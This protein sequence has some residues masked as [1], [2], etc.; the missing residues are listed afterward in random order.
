PP[1]RWRTSSATAAFAG[2][3]S[4]G[5]RNSSAR[6]AANSSTARTRERLVTTWRS[7]RAAP[8]PID[9][10]SSCIPE[11]GIEST[12]AGLARRRFSAT[13]A[14]AVYWAII[15]PELTPA[16]GARNGR[17]P[18]GGGD[19]Q[20]VAGESQRLAV[21]VAGRLQPAVGENHRVVHRRSQFAAGDLAGGLG[22]IAG[23][24]HDPGGA[25]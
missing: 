2:E 11:V 24:G 23:G 8:Q 6:E 7:L 17:S 20:E 12:L 18:P 3:D 5:A 19:R 25:A 10:W 13:M 15:S 4:R 16:S 22:G 1:P 14:A 9:T 21:E